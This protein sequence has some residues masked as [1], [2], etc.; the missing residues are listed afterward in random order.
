MS[1]GVVDGSLKTHSATVEI[2]FS[3]SS[4]E[5]PAS[6]TKVDEWRPDVTGKYTVGPCNEINGIVPGPDAY[7][8]GQ[9]AVMK[10]L[11]SGYDTAKHRQFSFLR[12]A[13][14]SKVTIVLSLG[15][16]QDW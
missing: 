3:T 14:Q 6:T 16:L 4:E 12:L 10:E 11:I 7:H 15:A 13:I 1:P 8:V 5:G 9:K 2:F